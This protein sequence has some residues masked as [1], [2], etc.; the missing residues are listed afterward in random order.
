MAR[1]NTAQ[2]PED[3]KAALTEFNSAVQDG[4]KKL[5]AMAEG[6]LSYGQ[7]IDQ[8]PPGNGVENLVEKYRTK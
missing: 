3:F 7:K 5:E 1:L 8:P 4:L 6:D 2:S